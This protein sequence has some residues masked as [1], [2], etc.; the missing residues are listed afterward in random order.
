[1]RGLDAVGNWVRDDRHHDAPSHRH[2]TRGFW[3]GVTILFDKGCAPHG[4]FKPKEEGVRPAGGPKKDHKLHGDRIDYGQSADRRERPY[5]GTGKPN[6]I[7]ADS[8]RQMS[9]RSREIYVQ[10]ERELYLNDAAN[11]LRGTRL[12][13]RLAASSSSS[14][15][16]NLIRVHVGSFDITKA[17]DVSRLI[18]IIEGNPGCDLWASIPCGPWSTWQYVNLSIHGAEFASHLNDLRRNSQVMFAAFL[19]ASRAVRQG[20]GRVA[21]EWPRHCLGWK[22][23]FMQRFLAD[24]DVET[25][26]F[27]GCDFGMQDKDG[28]PIRKQWKVATTSKEL[29][30]ELSGRKC[31]HEKG[32]LHARIEG[33]VTPT[34]ALYPSSMCEAIVGAWYPNGT[35]K[36]VANAMPVEVDP[37]EQ[38]WKKKPNTLYVSLN[39]ETAKIPTR[40]TSG[41]A[42]L[43]T[44]ASEGACIP[45]GGSGLV[46]TGISI[47][48]PAGVY[49]R[50]APRSGL[51]VKNRIAVGGGVIDPDYDGEIKV[52][53][54]NHGDEDFVVNPGDRIAQIVLE[55][56]MLIDASIVPRKAKRGTDRGSAGFGSTGIAAAAPTI[57]SDGKT[58]E[59]SMPRGEISLS[60]RPKSSVSLG[61]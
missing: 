56:V 49:A 23:P 54:F 39:S 53:L 41:S 21:F 18:G 48:M 57:G 17:K 55:R 12:L 47:E 43:D 59:F 61:Q 11:I 32:Y 58:F 34:T 24:P 20:G 46:S 38:R 60:H 6:S 1:M 52:I 19:R 29:I 37:V 13:Q 27:D 14:L 31:K 16:V 51:A 45:A 35:F 26:D 2:F 50:I 22:Q 15:H 30:D 9:T 40:A 42:G 4:R 33:S 8:W 3:T 10:T 44:Y 5:A 7:D 25:V 36:K 28:V